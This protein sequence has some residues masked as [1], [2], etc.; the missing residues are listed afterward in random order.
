MPAAGYEHRAAVALRTQPLA[1]QGR[2]L[3]FVNTHVEF[4]NLDVRMNQ[5]RTVIAFINDL[6]KDD[7]KAVI[8]V[9][10]DFNG[11]PW[12]NGYKLMSNS[13]FINTWA[14]FNNGDPYTGG[15]TIPA[16]WPGTRLDHV[17]YRAPSDVQVS[18]PYA[19]VLNVRLSDHRPYIV[20]L[21]FTVPSS[22]SPSTPKPTVAPSVAP[23]TRPTEAPTTAPTE[24]TVCV[25]PVWE[26]Q[27]IVLQCK[28]GQVMKRTVF[29]SYGTAT[30]SCGNFKLGNCIGGSSVAVVNDK[31]IGRNSCTFPNSNNVFGDPCPGT[32]KHFVAQVVC[33]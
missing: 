31:C 30:G 10:G 3:W 16:D 14:Q 21:S 12:D 7:P 33:G 28:A 20:K 5:L 25:G 4:Y 19:E 24:E 8:V 11:G 22:S 27:N 6:V 1:L 9:T 26:G 2:N 13:N 29:A 15:N 18:I 32:G 23:T 17:W